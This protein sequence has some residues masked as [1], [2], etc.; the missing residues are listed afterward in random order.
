MSDDI[1]GVTVDVNPNAQNKFIKKMATHSS[2]KT[3]D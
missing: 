3:S 1:V 2:A